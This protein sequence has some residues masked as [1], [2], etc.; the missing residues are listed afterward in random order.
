VILRTGAEARVYYD[1]NRM[2]NLFLAAERIHTA[3]PDSIRDV[4][5]LAA[6]NVVVKFSTYLDLSGVIN[7]HLT[8]LAVVYGPLYRITDG[9]IIDKGLG[10]D[11]YMRV[12]RLSAFTLGEQPSGDTDLLSVGNIGI[13]GINRL[14]PHLSINAGLLAVR[15]EVASEAANLEVGP[16]LYVNGKNDFH[17]LFHEQFMAIALDSNP[18]L[19]DRLPPSW[20]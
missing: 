2:Q 4:S 16:G 18:E 5:Q 8:R 11:K 13:K 9:E 19:A 6:G 1:Y 10:T 7:K 15:E 12:E 17:T 3:R 20:G 14:A